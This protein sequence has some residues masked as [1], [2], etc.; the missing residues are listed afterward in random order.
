MRIVFFFNLI[1]GHCC[2]LLSDR[3]T[4]RETDRQRH[5]HSQ[6]QTETERNIDQLLSCMHPNQGLNP[7]VELGFVP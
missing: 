1:Q 3:E 5:T 4:E 6:R 7:G 2:S